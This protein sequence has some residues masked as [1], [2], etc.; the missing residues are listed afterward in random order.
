VLNLTPEYEATG[1]EICKKLGK[2]VNCPVVLSM[3]IELSMNKK[4]EVELYQAL[5]HI[6]GT[7]K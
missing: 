6:L 2:E 7:M 4:G 5:L 3:N 1:E